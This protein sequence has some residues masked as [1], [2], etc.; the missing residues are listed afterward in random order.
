[1]R[2]A[3]HELV[4]VDGAIADRDALVAGFVRATGADRP[5]DVVVLDPGGDGISQIGEA[6]ATRTGLTAVHILSHGRDGA[7]QLGSATLD[8]AT[9]DARAEAISAWGSAFA[10]DGDLLLY[11]CDVADSIAGEAF[12]GELAR[13]TGAD[14]AASD[15]L[16]GEAGL[17][18]DWTLEFATGAI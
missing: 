12:V 8:A 10:G 14:V 5:V 11:G 7:I 6:L 15:D 4:F 13:A 18:G 9:L 1:M 3:A 16:T 17:G 2:L